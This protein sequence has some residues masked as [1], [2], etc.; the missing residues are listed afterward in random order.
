MKK[1]LTL[2]VALGL[3]LFVFFSFSYASGEKEAKPSEKEPIKLIYWD[4]AVLGSSYQE[5]K[6]DKSEWYITKAIH[7]FEEQN[8]GVTIELTYQDG[9]KTLEMMTAAAMAGT[10]PDVVSMWGGVYVK[11]ISDSLLDLKEYFAPEEIAQVRGWENHAVGG[12]YFGAPITSGVTCIWYNKEIFEKAGVNA[13]SYDGTIAGLMRICEKLKAAGI[14]PMI[15]GVAD[16]WGLSWLEGS[17]FASQVR[18]VE[19]IMA[20]IV[21]GERDFTATPELVKAFEANQDLFSRGYYNDDVLTIT[22][23]E[24]YTLFVN[25]QGA[26]FPGWNPDLGGLRETLGDNLGLMPMPALSKDAK[27]FGSVVGGIGMNAFVA[28][29]YGKHPEMSTKFIR[30]LRTYEEEKLNIKSTGFMPCVKG[31]YSD[32]VTD[33]YELWFIEY[34]ENND[35]P[36]MLDNLMPGIV[37]SVWWELEIA[38]LSGQMSAVDFLKEWDKARDEALAAR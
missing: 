37:A 11:E 35:V 16:G 28:P 17:I 2:M 32:V 9:T 25:G 38:M 14:T 18:D 27:N 21:A 1:I 10:G 31:D 3:C 13:E 12:K 5:A 33:P 15:N 23:G 24:S 22:Q 4:F 8:P 30:F 29:E 19:G 7:K 26:M 20:D 34:A 6:K 36:L